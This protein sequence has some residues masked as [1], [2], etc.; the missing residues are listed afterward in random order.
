MVTFCKIELN[1]TDKESIGYSEKMIQLHGNPFPLH[2][3]TRDRRRKT[4]GNSISQ[5]GTGLSS[6]LA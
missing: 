5:I 6:Q 4:V 1:F 2:F 3:P